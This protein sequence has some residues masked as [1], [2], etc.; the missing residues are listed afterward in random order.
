MKK[1]AILIVLALELAVCG[2]GTHTIANTTLL[3]HYQR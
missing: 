2:C 1:L 3:Y